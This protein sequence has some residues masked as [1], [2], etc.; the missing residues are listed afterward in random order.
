MVRV[1]TKP[2]RKRKP[3]AGSIPWS[4]SAAD[5]AAEA[6]AIYEER[7]GVHGRDVDD[8][9]QAERRVAARS[10]RHQNGTE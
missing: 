7:G 1:E 9:L 10:R 3:A 4:I 8:W 2:V 5:I 6:Y